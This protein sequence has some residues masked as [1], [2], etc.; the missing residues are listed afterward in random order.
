MSGGADLVQGEDYYLENGNWV[1]TARYL[2]QR[3]YC[4]R[5]GC[6]RC[7]YGYVRDEDKGKSRESRPGTLIEI[8]QRAGAHPASMD[9]V[10]DY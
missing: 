4:C 8:R 2:L 6:R 3:G 9:L 10:S 1:F 7:P 5:C